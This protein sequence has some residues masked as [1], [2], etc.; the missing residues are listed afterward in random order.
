YEQAISIKSKSINVS[1]PSVEGATRQSHYVSLLHHPVYKLQ[2][3]D[4]KNKDNNISKVGQ[5]ELPD[6]FHSRVTNKIRYIYKY[7]LN[8]GE[9]APIVAVEIDRP[10]ENPIMFNA[11]V[12]SL[13]SIGEALIEGISIVDLDI[14]TPNN[15]G[16]EEVR[17]HLPKMPEE[18]QNLEFSCEEVECIAAPEKDTDVYGLVLNIKF[19]QPINRHVTLNLKYEMNFLWK[20]ADKV[21]MPIISP[22]G[23]S[24]SN[25]FL[26][27]S[28]KSDEA[29][30]SNELGIKDA[31]DIQKTGNKYLNKSGIYVETLGLEDSGKIWPMQI[32][33]LPKSLLEK[34]HDLKRP[35]L[36][37][38]RYT[39]LGSHYLLPLKLGR[40]ETTRSTK[41]SEAHYET[42]FGKQGGVYT[43]ATFEVENTQSQLLEIKLPKGSQLIS[44]TVGNRLDGQAMERA[45]TAQ[46][47]K[48]SVLVNL[49]KSDDPF[50]IQ[51]Q[52][53]YE[54]EPLG[55]WGTLEERLPILEGA[56]VGHLL[57]DVYLPG[58]AYYQ[59]MPGE[60]NL[61]VLRSNL[62]I[63]MRKMK[64][65]FKKQT[66]GEDN[67][68]I[69]FSFSQIYSDDQNLASKDVTPK[70]KKE[71]IANN[72]PKY[73]MMYVSTAAQVVGQVISL[74]STFL[75]GSALILFTIKVNQ[76]LHIAGILM[77]S[78]GT[79][80]MV[81]AIAEMEADMM[82][83]VYVGSIFTVIIVVV[84]TW[85]LWTVI[86]QE[87]EEDENPELD[88]TSKES[89]KLKKP[90]P[91][92]SESKQIEPEKN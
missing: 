52:Y 64:Y 88:S 26:A 45:R 37:A 81:Y 38:F 35:I 63:N 5:Q 41:I 83:T 49:I 87:D 44:V 59:V 43:Q 70:K 56:L 58:G 55:F 84:W 29:N 90:K 92:K 30:K 48:N 34:T 67:H 85:Q 23:A 82:P 65:T 40:Y 3:E 21:M 77:V 4:E 13:I 50:N 46:L 91:D 71:A 72:V 6:F 9:S 2:P 39:Y 79:A 10:E 80:A 1:V 8:K 28:L 62:D 74:F 47:D 78:S 76:V 60:T 22:E 51:L 17:L 11:Q 75:I 86:N 27:I 24:V 42:L 73:S 18:L 32:N 57:W 69:G 12:S 15:K 54:G 25:G 68:W 33:K 14:T 16:L 31:S 89:L 53:S 7:H 19:S 36:R 61:E 66:F 20:D